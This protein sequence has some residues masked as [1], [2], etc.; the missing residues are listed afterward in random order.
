MLRR[1]LVLTALLFAMPAYAGDNNGANGENRCDDLLDGCICSETFDVN[2]TLPG[3]GITNWN[4]SNSTSKQCL[5]E[6]QN[7]E[8]VT[9]TRGFSDSVMIQANAAGKPF[10]VGNPYI[11]KTQ[12]WAVHHAQ[13]NAVTLHNQTLCVR[14]YRR[15]D[16]G[17]A[18]GV[19]GPE[20]RLKDLEISNVG[21]ILTHATFEGSRNNIH[22]EYVTI[23]DTRYTCTY[24]D[25]VSLAC[26]GDL[27]LTQEWVNGQDALQNGWVR[28]EQCVDVNGTTAV[29]RYYAT[30]LNTG[31]TSSWRMPPTGTGTN[32]PDPVVF[33]FPDQQLFSQT[34]DWPGL[35]QYL[36]YIMEA[37]VPYNPSFV[38]G[39]AAE[40]DNGTIPPPTPV[41]SCFASPAA[42][43]PGDA[44][45]VD[46]ISSGFSGTDGAYTFD[47]NGDGVLNT[48]GAE[49]GTLGGN[50][51]TTPGTCT[52]S[53]ATNQFSP[54]SYTLKCAMSSVS[55]PTP[56]V[57]TTPLTV[58]APP[59]GIPPGING[60]AKG[61]F[62][63]H[64][65]QRKLI[66][67]ARG[68]R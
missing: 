45:H 29:Y 63:M 33:N 34:N 32:G 19:P 11:Y 12:V 51:S 37:V 5:G 68:G 50:C 21:A 27:E 4:P 44:Y 24:T 20:Q 59:G 39:P 47:M 28:F 64:Q 3:G 30:P 40:I 67:L 56:L 7:G 53:R 2:D 35:H 31:V 58:N 25:F 41:V 46:A 61:S 52:C 54:A 43:L 48:C 14:S 1:L 49:S 57:S 16:L 26:P 18:S 6:N 42:I 22:N 23:V 13:M 38:I 17:V 8:T 10:P 15:R 55:H 60:S 36:S 66:Q 62:T 65:L 9:N